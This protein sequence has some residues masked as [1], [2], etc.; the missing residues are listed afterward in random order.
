MTDK[1]RYDLL[2]EQIRTLKDN[3]EAWKQAFLATSAWLE[4]RDRNGRILAES[5]G[6]RDAE[7]LEDAE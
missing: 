1:E 5:R 6:K 4:E 7:A 3:A 2:M